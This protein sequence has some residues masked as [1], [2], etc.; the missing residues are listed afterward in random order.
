VKIFY[1]L[2]AASSAEEERVR[3]II[4]EQFDHL[5]P[6]LHQATN[7]TVFSIGHRLPTLPPGADVKR[8]SQQG[9]EEFTL[10]ALWEYCKSKP[11]F[12]TKVVYLHSKGSYL[13][14]ITRQRQVTRVPHEWRPLHGMRSFARLLQCVFL[15][16][17]S[18]TPSSHAW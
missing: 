3:D 10:R 5:N 4:Y 8:H 15:S 18:V 12:E 2:F 14:P 16:N 6:E 11:H 1:N 7:V 9:N 17:E 13:P